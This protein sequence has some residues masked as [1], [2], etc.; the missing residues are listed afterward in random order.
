MENTWGYDDA[1]IRIA[2][3]NVV[4]DAMW[5]VPADKSSPYY[6]GL[7][8]DYVQYTFTPDYAAANPVIRIPPM[9]SIGAPP[10]KSRPAPSSASL[11]G[12]FQGNTL[13][14]VLVAAAAFLVLRK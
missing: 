10:A 5:G 3:G 4:P 8:A 14:L 7:S 11:A 12:L 1:L 9:V 13:V 2:N 6:G